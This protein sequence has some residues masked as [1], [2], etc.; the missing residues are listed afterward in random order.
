MPPVTL[1]APL[2]EELSIYDRILESDL[3][4]QPLAVGATTFK[5]TVA[6][7]IDLLIEQQSPTL[8]WAKLPRGESWQL[9]LERYCRQA[10][11][12]T[13]AC[14]FDTSP[15]A[16]SGLD[17]CQEQRPIDLQLQVNAAGQLSLLSD[18]GVNWLA[19]NLTAPLISIPV[20]SGNFCRGEYFILAISPHFQGLLLARRSRPTRSSQ[21]ANGTGYS[22]GHTNGYTHGYGH[23]QGHPS[24]GESSSLSDRNAASRLE[25][26]LD[27][28]LSAGLGGN[29]K[30]SF[31]DGL[32]ENFKDSDSFDTTI[33]G[34]LTSAEDQK[35]QLR[36]FYSCQPE[37]VHQTL[38]ILK[39]AVGRVPTNQ[40]PVNLGSAIAPAK[41]ATARLEVSGLMRH[42]S[43]LFPVQAAP[44]PELAVLSHWVM[45][46]FQRQEELWRRANVYRKQAELA[47]S[48]E[49]QLDEALNALRAKDEFLDMVVQELRT[50]LTNMKTALSLLSSPNL[51][52]FQR[53]RYTQLLNTECDRQGSLISGLL[54]LNQI[55]QAGDT[56]M[57][58]LNLLDIV[59]GVVST[60]QP[61]AQEKELMLAYTIPADLPP[62]ACLSPWLRQ[63]IVNLLHNSIKFTA[64][65]GRVWVRAKVQGD[66][67]QIDIQDTGIGIASGEIPKIFNRFYRV[68]ASNGEDFSGAGLGLTIVQQLLLRCSGSITV[69]SR[70]GQGSTFSVLLPIAPPS[71][72]LASLAG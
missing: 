24:A 63:I 3:I 38:G 33:S 1:H 58:P 39:A 12:A 11:A 26:G 65:G 23:T 13:L 22:N 35:P 16:S 20:G 43:K 7:F 45:K 40:L 57:Q 37:V 32:K 31:K 71:F 21:S 67:V 42:W 27:T 50:P 34:D 2:T 51:K 64:K 15:Q 61:L 52:P 9:E 46:Q 4:V 5:A 60:Y 6:S 29:V 68:R 47:E 19:E 28:N 55:E 41:S 70:L 54:N 8:L 18:T 48:L 25:T 59:P 69:N 53:Q 44:N 30:D 36:L 62:V 10:N 14:V 66:Y 56:T 49:G 72:D 17:D